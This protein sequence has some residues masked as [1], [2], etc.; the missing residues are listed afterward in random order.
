MALVRWSSSHVRC[1]PHASWYAPLGDTKDG[2]RGFIAMLR[3]HLHQRYSFRN[4]T[5]LA[6]KKESKP[7]TLSAP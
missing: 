1:A 4:S 2:A 5:A 7:K 6:T 3:K